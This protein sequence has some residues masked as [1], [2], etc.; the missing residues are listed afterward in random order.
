MDNLGSRHSASWQPFWLA[1]K[2]MKTFIGVAVVLDAI[3]IR[4]VCQVVDN[5]TRAPR[6]RMTSSNKPRVPFRQV[7]DATTLHPNAIGARFYAVIIDPET[8]KRVCEVPIYELRPGEVVELA[9]ER[10]SIFNKGQGY[11]EA[12]T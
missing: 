2:N 3:P 6:N 4:V 12:P 8:Q 1:I 10:L 7:L 11:N 5:H 9:L